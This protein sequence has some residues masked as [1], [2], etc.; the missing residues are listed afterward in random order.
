MQQANL[1]KD[2]EEKNLSSAKFTAIML[3]SIVPPHYDSELF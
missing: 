1:L 3:T 2:A